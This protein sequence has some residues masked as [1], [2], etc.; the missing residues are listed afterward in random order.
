LSAKSKLTRK[1]LKAPDEFITVTTKGLDWVAAHGRKL[2][3][4]G[5]ALVVLVAGLWAWQHLSKRGEFAASGDFAEALD[6]YRRP[7]KGERGADEQDE[8]RKPFESAKAR[9]QAALEKFLAVVDRHRGAPVAQLAQ[10]Y[11]GNCQY[12]LGEPD[13]AI[14][15][16]E[17]F[18]AAPVDQPHLRALALENLGYAHERKK[19]HAKALEAFERLSREKIL[20]ERGLYHVA[21]VHAQNGD[22]VKAKDYYQKALEKAKQEKVDWFAQE[23]ESKLALLELAP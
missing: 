18:L 6:V 10:L 8:V 12:T 7:L 17:A 2:V 19:D 11:I 3:V 5:V 1:E 9:A 15:A 14:A 20:G 21:R 22:K 13:K 23:I 16:Y 4:A